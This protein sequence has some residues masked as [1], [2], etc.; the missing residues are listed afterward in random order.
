MER[1]MT[2]S[3]ILRRAILLP[4]S[5]LVLISFVNEMIYVRALESN[6]KTQV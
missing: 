3:V 4:S 2:T 6:P 5:N 1:L